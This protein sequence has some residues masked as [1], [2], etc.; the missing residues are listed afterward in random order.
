MGNDS[1]AGSRAHTQAITEILQSDYAAHEEFPHLR[2]SE[3][4]WPRN[5]WNKMKEAFFKSLSIIQYV[6]R[7]S[8]K[9]GTL[10]TV[11]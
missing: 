10:L 3:S 7:C 2:K 4:N 11:R 8:N 9:N 1:T 5:E 6:N